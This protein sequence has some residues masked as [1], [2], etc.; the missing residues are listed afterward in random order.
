TRSLAR[1]WRW[2][3]A[4]SRTSWRASSQRA[5]TA[6][7]PAP[8]SSASSP[9]QPPNPTR[10]P[11]R[12]PRTSY[13]QPLRSG[14]REWTGTRLMFLQQSGFVAALGQS[15]TPG[16]HRAPAGRHGTPQDATGISETPGLAL[17]EAAGCVDLSAAGELDPGAAAK[18]GRELLLGGLDQQPVA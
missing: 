17:A 8:P 1:S 14:R 13:P 6:P 9:Q 12:P 18:F 2:P 5:R 7:P 16:P 3:I 11:P 4:A 15:A 10:P